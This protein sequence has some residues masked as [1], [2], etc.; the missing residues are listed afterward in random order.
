MILRNSTNGADYD[1]SVHFGHHMLQEMSGLT[2]SYDK[3]KLSF[4]GARMS[5]LPRPKDS[6]GLPGWAIALIVV[7][8]LLVLG[9]IGT[10]IWYYR[11]KKANPS[12]E[13]AEI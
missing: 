13:Y 7:G 12:G 1:E 2:Y 4:E 6:G 10:G 9:G 8:S 5:D 3:K 11:K